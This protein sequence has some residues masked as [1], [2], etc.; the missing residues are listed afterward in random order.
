MSDQNK[1]RGQAIRALS[2]QLERLC[3]LMRGYERRGTPIPPEVQKALVV[4]EEQVAAVL[5][6]EQHTLQ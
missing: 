5:Q 4:I 3:D 6:L 2:A 1:R